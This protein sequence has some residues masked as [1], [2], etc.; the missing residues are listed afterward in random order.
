LRRD[1]LK[2]AVVSDVDMSS[3]IAGWRLDADLAVDDGH[4][5]AQPT[6]PGDPDG[7]GWPLQEIK[8]RL[9][10]PLRGPR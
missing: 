10:G 2:G 8:T 1:E 3:E 5:V 7:N 4:R 9:P 6:P